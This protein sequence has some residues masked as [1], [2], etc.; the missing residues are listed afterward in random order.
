MKIIKEVNEINYR[1]R[2]YG[3]NHTVLT[4]DIFAFHQLH[5]N[6]DIDTQWASKN[7]SGES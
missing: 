6:Y 7:V 3:Q 4:K 1:T 5:G 2:N